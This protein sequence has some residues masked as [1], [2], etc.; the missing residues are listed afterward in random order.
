MSAGF[1]ARNLG[2]AMSENNKIS[3]GQGD[4]AASQKLLNLIRS[5]GARVETVDDGTYVQPA[6]FPTAASRQKGESDPADPAQIGHRLTGETPAVQEVVFGSDKTAAGKKEKHLGFGVL[7]RQASSYWSPLFTRRFD[8]DHS[9]GVAY[10]ESGFM[11]AHVEHAGRDHLKDVVYYEYPVSLVQSIDRLNYGSDKLRQY[12]DEHKLEGRTAVN[13]FVPPEIEGQ[14]Y[15]AFFQLPSGLKTEERDAVAVLAARREA[16]FDPENSIF[17][18]RPTGGYRDVFC[19]SVAPRAGVEQLAAQVRAAGV[20]LTGMI[21]RTYINLALF[22]APW[23][24]RLPWKNYVTLTVGHDI[25]NILLVVNQRPTVIRVLPVGTKNFEEAMRKATDTGEGEK[26]LREML[27]NI[28]F[29]MRNG[30]QILTQK[31]VIDAIDPVCHRIAEF[32]RRIVKLYAIRLSVTFEGTRIAGIPILSHQ[33]GETL[34]ETTR[35]PC[36]VQSVDELM[37]DFGR[38][39]LSDY[40]K[41]GKSGLI[42]ESVSLALVH[43]FV[44][45]LLETPDIR[46][47]AAH[48]QHI[49]QTVCLSFIAVSIA[50]LLYSGYNGIKIWQTE[51]AI[52]RTE[53]ALAFHTPKISARDIDRALADL[54]NYQNMGLNIIDRRR[55]V[56]RLTDLTM[57]CPERIE[58]ISLRRDQ[59]KEVPKGAAKGGRPVTVSENLIL[60]ARV[61]GDKIARATA[62]TDFLSAVRA[63]PRFGTDISLEAEPVEGDAERFTMTIRG[64]RR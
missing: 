60:K 50:A 52:A 29:E 10:E 30:E 24:R 54:V 48:R 6:A 46:R 56:V 21:S 45:N 51:R 57:A 7:S 5:S 8:Y 55:W 63:N 27:S 2:T 12:I 33:L 14:G 39:R 11:I 42:L 31:A 1:F 17:D 28:A 15:S 38:L 32:V 22:G 61:V 13:V 34:R 3:G 9:L 19:A 49:L 40:F 59:V 53:A 37:D 16:E 26:N 47:R 64:L 41:K 20:P 36:V 43:R 25:T 62:L 23:A 4:L 18:Y 35:M 58:F 44:P